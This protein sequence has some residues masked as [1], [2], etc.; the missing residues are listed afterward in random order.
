[1]AGAV[2]SLL[3]SGEGVYYAVAGTV[4]SRVAEKSAPFVARLAVRGLAK[5][6]ANADLSTSIDF[7]QGHIKH[8]KGEWEAL[9][10][11]IGELKGVERRHDDRPEVRDP[12]LNHPEQ[13]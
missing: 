2:L 5:G 9:I 11:G 8:A 3:W 6:A 13:P 12:T 7:M 1:M 10:R 4:S